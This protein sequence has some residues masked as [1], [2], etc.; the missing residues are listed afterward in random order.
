MRTIGYITPFI[1]ANP[2]VKTILYMFN[3]EESADVV[4]EVE[5]ERVET[6]SDH[7]NA[8]TTTAFHAHRIILQKSCSS[9]LLGELCKSGE[10]SV[11]ITDVKPAVFKHV[12]YYIYGGKI[13]DEDIWANAKEIIDAA[14]KYGIVGLKLEAE[15]YYFVEQVHYHGF[16]NLPTQMDV[17]V[18]SPD[19]TCFGH[20]WRIEIYPDGNAS[21]EDGM[22]SI[23]LRNRSN[24]SIKVQFGLSI[25]SK[26]KAAKR[27]LAG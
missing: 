26:I 19:F 27:R 17:P 3:D 16:L 13:A 21:A 6:S 10:T 23:G 8:K 24:K 22:V 11:S 25:I 20:T 5:N 9:A 18:L 15:A 1:P 14:D 7:K 12:L 2:F 4:F